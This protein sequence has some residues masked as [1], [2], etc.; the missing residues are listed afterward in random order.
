[1][2]Y[3]WSGALV[4]QADGLVQELGHL[5][6]VGVVLSARPGLD[7]PEVLQF[8]HCLFGEALREKAV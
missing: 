5:L 7:E 8:V 2:P 3:L 1:M 6:V 4:S